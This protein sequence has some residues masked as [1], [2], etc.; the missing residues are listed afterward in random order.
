MSCEEARAI[1]LLGRVPYGRVATSMR[2]LPFV[3]PARHIVIDGRVLLR[4]HAGLGYHHACLGSVVAY[5][6]DNLGSGEVD[7]WSVQFTGTA[8]AF[9]PTA[10]ELALFGDDPRAVDGEPFDPVYMRIEPQFVTVHSLDY[11]KERQLKYVA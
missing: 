6:A 10:G 1:E 11:S 5:G 9:E 2:A 4:L 7:V 8:E 3:A